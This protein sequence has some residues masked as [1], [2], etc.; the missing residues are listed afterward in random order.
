ML[1]SNFIIHYHQK[2]FGYNTDVEAET[3]I[4]WP[5][6]AKCW[7]IG[8][9]PVAGKDFGQEE[10]GMPEDKIIGCHHWLNGHGLGGLQELVI[11]REAWH[12]M[13]GGVAKSQTRLRDWTELN[14]YLGCW[15]PWKNMN[16]VP[17]LIFKSILV[18]WDALLLNWTVYHS[19][20]TSDVNS[21]QTLGLIFLFFP[22]QFAF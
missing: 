4:F 11:H 2:W 21:Y 19:S 10:E 22:F 17:L 9:D 7:L 18:I 13:V 3:P 12:S 20:Y 6:D 16:W 5:P 8:K 15:P 1:N 14:W